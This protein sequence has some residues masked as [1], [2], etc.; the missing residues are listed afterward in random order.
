MKDFVISKNRIIVFAIIVVVIISICFFCS[1]TKQKT[2]MIREIDRIIAEKSSISESNMVYIHFSFDDVVY[3]FRDLRKEEY[4]SIFEES[5]F[6]YLQ[7]MHIKYGAKFSLYTYNEELKEL[8]GK[9]ASD[10]ASNS[11]W[12]KIGLHSQYEGLLLSNTKYEKAKDYWEEFINNIKRICGTLD[13]VD[14]MPRLEG[15]AGSLEALKGMRDANYGALG[16]LDAS[17]SRLSYYLTK[18]E[19][20]HL[21]KNDY[22]KD[23]ENRLLFL[24]TDIRLETYEAD[25]YR[26]LRVN[27]I[28]EELIQ[29]NQ[30]EE[31]RSSR[32]NM[33][34]F[35]HEWYVYDGLRMKSNIDMVEA[36]C[37]YTRKYG[38]EFDYPQ[39]R[40]INN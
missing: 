10:F 19:I 26:D 35:T 22:L 15:A 5:F 24:S 21:C 40:P 37:Y 18:D 30:N 17:D 7:S 4:D 25:G 8:S 32:Q 11:D 1:S 31:Y 27:G 33:L 16:F 6:R 12:L 36:V 2:D 23:E 3:S 34:I 20:E 9:Y 13:V 39:N 14:R 29:R 38:I 28:I